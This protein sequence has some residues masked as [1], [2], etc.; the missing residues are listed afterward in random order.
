MALAKTEL[1]LARIMGPDANQLEFSDRKPFESAARVFELAM[2]CCDN[3]KWL[4]PLAPID[5]ELA[6]RIA[7]LSPLVEKYKAAL[8]PFLS[9]NRPTDYQKALLEARINCGMAAMSNMPLTEHINQNMHK[10]LF[11]ELDLKESG[12]QE[13]FDDEARHEFIEEFI[14]V[15]KEA[16]YWEIFK[17]DPRIGNRDN[18]FVILLKM[19]Q[20]GFV[21]IRFAKVNDQQ[22]LTAHHPLYMGAIGRPQGSYWMGCWTEGDKEMQYM[23]LWADDCQYNRPVD[24]K[25][26]LLTAKRSVVPEYPY[27]Q[28]GYVTWEP[29]E[30]LVE[31]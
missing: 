16:V 31:A 19:Y 8:A 5:K 1:R 26:S 24:L 25:Q 20:L 30:E 27:K 11:L 23:H 6:K 9:K 15:A 14:D 18:P 21:D 12:W 13:D 7:D 4:D 2:S 10:E 22:K 17:S 3:P 29:E 28:K